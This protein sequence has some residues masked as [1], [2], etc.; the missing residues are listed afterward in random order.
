[1]TDV[2]SRLTAALAG[3][4]D[5]ERE[6]G[7][8]GMATVYLAEDVKHHRKVAV[9]V[10]R[11]DLAAALGPE[12]FIR[13]IE[14][15]ANLTHPHIVPL[16]DSGESDG[17]LYYVLP[18]IEGESL[19]DKVTR[20]GELPIGDAVRI[21]RD[22]VD[23]LS[24]AHERGV[25]HRD[26]KPDNVLLT[27]HHA[28]VM[29]FGVAKAVSEATGRQALTTAGVALGTPA[30]MAPEQA[31]ADPH[32]DHR[33]DIYAVGAVAYELLTGRT[34]FAGNTPQAILSAQVTE[35]PDPVSKH[36]KSV[37]PVLEQL[38]MKCLEKKPADRWQ[39]AEEMLPHL[40]ALATPSGGI[41]P[42]GTMPITAVQPR[43]S[44]R[45]AV[46]TGITVAVA[47]LGFLGWFSL[48]GAGPVVT[49][50]NI[51]QLTRAPEV[52]IDPQ[53]SPDGGEVVYTAGFGLD[54]HLYVRDIG[55]GRSLALT[56]DRPGRQIN[57]RWTP[58]G[59]TIAFTQAGTILGSHSIPRLGG[60][61]RTIAAEG[62]VW[63]VHDDRVVFTRQDSL[64]VQSI[65]GGGPRLAAFAQPAPHS[66]AWSPDG[67]RLAYV[68]GNLNFIMRRT[69][70][71][72]AP[73]SIWIVLLEDGKPVQVTDDASMNM[74][75]VWL[76]DGQ[77]L[78]FI[79]NRDGP[80][81]LY[82]VQVDGSG[83]SRGEPVRVTTGLDAHSVSLSAD[84][85]TAAYSKFTFRRNVWEVD[86]PAAGSVS[87][88]EARPITVGNQLVENHGLSP[89]GRWL[90]FDSNLDGNQ[91]I[92]VV[93]ADGGEPR[94]M[95]TD[96]GDDFHPD[97]SGDGS[98]IVF[99]SMRYGSRDLFLIAADGSNEVRLT[100]DPGN[101]N[102]PSFSPDGLK[103]AFGG[104]G[105]RTLSREAVGGEWSGPRQLTRDGG[106]AGWSPDGSRIV[107][108][109]G[110]NLGIASPQGEER[111]LLEGGAVGFAIANWPEWSPDGRSIYFGGTDS[112]GSTGIFEIPVAGGQARQR[113][114]FDDPTKNFGYG[115]SVGNG[116]VYLS[117][118]EYES[119]IYVMDLV[120]R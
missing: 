78:L 17:F 106:N 2:L 19:R 14:I 25:V 52:E 35:A 48:S 34:L 22:V 36:R 32:V 90:A 101:E 55:G 3:R 29:D 33:A 47:M 80:R 92:Y 77:H 103:I 9:K 13:E 39:S 5:I 61:T 102:H 114:R 75:P 57:P 10:L 115:F 70:G 53:I 4:Y 111:L 68:Q 30:Y 54:M 59:R 31:V 91:D 89:D 11:P 67:S 20:E 109:G 86:I 8:G 15:A 94:R 105:I 49:V 107:F 26:I 16:Y 97:F 118:A 60:P 56:A 50:T 44:V 113:I 23:A 37:P 71:N 82:V 84:G 120:I 51:R 116:K 112:T 27:K 98:E 45:P 42:T 83:R 119:D 66:A 88:A 104:Q 69:L 41:T 108:G 21:L 93:S 1:M 58:D 28:V 62:V 73:S 85:S 72:V 76:P 110:N 24:D 43:S 87:I 64:L 96:P 18:Y 100:D 12:R 7:A 95:T 6:I 117:V 65:E 74:S 63:G 81:D 99:Y 46:L 79:S 40:E 38:V